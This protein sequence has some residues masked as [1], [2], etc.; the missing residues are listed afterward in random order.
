MLTDGTGGDVA[1]AEIGTTVRYSSEYIGLQIGKDKS[2]TG[3]LWP[4]GLHFG[5]FRSSM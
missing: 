3:I 5:I 1:G 2:L 4:C